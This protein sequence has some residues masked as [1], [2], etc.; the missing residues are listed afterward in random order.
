[1]YE[2]K[3]VR[4]VL[5]EDAPFKVVTARD[6]VAYVEKNCQPKDEQWREMA[7]VLTLNK[8]NVIT[9]HFQLS[10]GGTAS[11][12]IDKKVVAKVAVD[13]L[14]DAVILVHNHPS[15]RCVPSQ[16]DIRQTGEVKKAL[17]LFDIRLLDHVIIGDGEYFSFAAEQMAIIK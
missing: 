14:A 1:M 5:K 4:S 11:T 7:W 6:V 13:Q 3:L 15:G 12:D 16:A 8:A 10:V 2:I 17:D 9:G